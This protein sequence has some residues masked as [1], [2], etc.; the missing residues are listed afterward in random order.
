MRLTLFCFLFISIIHTAHAQG[1][2]NAYKNLEVKIKIATTWIEKVRR[3]DYSRNTATLLSEF[4]TFIKPDTLYN[5]HAEHIEEGYGRVLNPLFADV[6]SDGVEE[7]I[8]LLGWDISSP[9]LCVFKNNNG[10]WYLIYRE[11]TDTFYGAPTLYLANNF[12]RS[13]VF[14]FRHVDYHGTGTYADSYSFY[15]L[16][17]DKVYKCLDLIN[18]I[19]TYGS[20]TRLSQAVTVKFDFNGD[21]DDGIW[22]TYKYNFFPGI[23]NKPNCT[24]CANE[25]IPLVKGAGGVGYKWDGKAFEYKLDVQPYQSKADD[26]NADKIACFGNFSNYTLFVKAFRAQIKETL[27]IGTVK[28]KSLLRAYLMLVKKAK[29]AEQQ[30]IQKRKL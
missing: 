11:Q 13:K 2:G 17:G 27:K 19:S 6:D 5:P 25:D 10:S 24:W 20:G 18:D 12:S 7:L 28:Q 9:Y 30:K 29:I 26:L 15:K 4:Q 3:F 8:C 16:I 21:E 1:E 23:E 14:Y 22:V